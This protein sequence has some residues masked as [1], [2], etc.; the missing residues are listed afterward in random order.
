MVSFRQLN[1]LRDPFPDATVRLADFDL[2][3][4]RNVFIYFERPA[5]TRVLTKCTNTLSMGGYLLT[6]QPSSM[7][8]APMSSVSSPFR[9]RLSI[10]GST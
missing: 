3:L 1:L 5:V 2:I 9:S 6:G 10:S 7:T 8:R 4:C